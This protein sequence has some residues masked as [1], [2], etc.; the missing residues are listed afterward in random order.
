MDLS[1]IQHYI[2]NKRPGDTAR[3]LISRDGYLETIDSKLAAAPVFE[4]RIYK[5]DSASEEQQ[6]FFKD[7]MFSDWNLPLEYTEYTPSPQRP[8]QFDYV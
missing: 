5:N 7:W 8:K 1:L 6:R 2:A 3:I 4:Y